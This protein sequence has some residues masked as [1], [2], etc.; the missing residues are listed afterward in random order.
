VVESLSQPVIRIAE[1]T[2]GS[3]SRKTQVHFRIFPTAVGGWDVNNRL[4]ERYLVRMI[5]SFQ[6]EVN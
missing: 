5:N 6:V 1:I 3:I 2:S 4:F